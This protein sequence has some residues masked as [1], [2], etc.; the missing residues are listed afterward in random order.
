MPVQIP[1]AKLREICDPFVSNPWMPFHDGSGLVLERSA[2]E[3]ALVS[4]NV[5]ER[6]YHTILEDQDTIAYHVARI[7]YL[8]LHGWTD[9]IEIDVG[10]PGLGCHVD[11]VVV[12]GNHRL[13]AA[14]FR[15]D[16]SIMAVV[17]GDINYG[18]ELF[19]VDVTEDYDGCKSD[20]A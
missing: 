12:D 9:P 15:G 14:I 11:W 8:V 4:G 2:I 3:A 20:S 19:G 13:A 1:I 17:D 16:E 6:P 18:S 7:A 5:D 10:V